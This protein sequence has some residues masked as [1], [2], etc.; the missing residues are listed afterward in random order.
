MHFV[1]YINYIRGVGTFFVVNNTGFS[2][3]EG[4]TREVRSNTPSA[5][6]M[7]LAQR[8]KRFG[9]YLASLQTA[10]AKDSENF[11]QGHYR[12]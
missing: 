1:C 9:T 11:E 4:F 5:G 3:G 6:S 12:A 8:E 2:T 10:V 7:A